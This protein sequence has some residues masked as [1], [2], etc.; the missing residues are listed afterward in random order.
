M[1]PRSLTSSSLRQLVSVEGVA[2]KVSAIKPKVV[3]SVH[4]CPETK[5]HLEREYRDATDPELGLHAIDSQ[6]RELPDRMIGITPTAFPQ[7][8]SDAHLKCF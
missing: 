8:E 4:Y 5:Q 3:R 6:G 7:K 1:S 2:T